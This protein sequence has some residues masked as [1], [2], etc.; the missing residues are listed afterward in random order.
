MSLPTL[1][2]LATRLKLRHYSLLLELDR[3]RSVSRA[4]ERLG[5]AQPTVTRSLRE[6]EDIFMTQLFTRSRRGLEPT[7]A[8][9]LVLARARLALADADGLGQDLAALGS[10]LQGRLRVGVIPFL[11]RQ[12]HDSLWH[13]LLA[14]R[15]RMGFVAEEA[16]TGT[17]RQALLARRLDCAICRFTSAITETGLEQHFLYHQ[18]PRLVVSRDAAERLARRGLDWAALVSM[19]WIFPPQHTPVREMIH[20]IFASAGQTVPMPFMEAFAHK[21]LASVLRHMPDAITILPD[22]IAQ[23]VADTSGARVMPQRLQWN[24]PPVGM[25]RLRDAT[26][27]ALVDDLAEAIRHAR[28]APG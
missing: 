17:L 23:E 18:E 24:L 7:S 8:G 14:L 4:A 22:D 26:H 13:H 6:I 27:G 5:L 9:L 11:S 15:P 25:V 20:S 21:T 1:P 16:T 2:W 19:Q 3:S 10:G 12:T 28:L